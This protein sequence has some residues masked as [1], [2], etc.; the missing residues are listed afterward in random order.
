MTETLECVAEPV[1]LTVRVC[2]ADIVIHGDCARRFSRVID[3]SA[4]NF[5]SAESG[6][7]CTAY[8]N[9]EKVADLWATHL[10]I[11]RGVSCK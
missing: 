1:L 6:T 8:W 7:A 10:D 5:R 4:E 9:G 11:E 2:D 3:A